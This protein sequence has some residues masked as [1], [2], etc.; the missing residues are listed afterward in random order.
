M[1]PIEDGVVT[2]P[3][4]P[5]DKNISS[6]ALRLSSI[7][8][9]APK[10]SRGLSIDLSAAPTNL[11]RW[12]HGIALTAAT[13]RANPIANAGPTITPSRAPNHR[14]TSCTLRQ[15]NKRLLLLA[16]RIQVSYV[17]LQPIALIA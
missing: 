6:K 1:A 9:G 5:I 12:R 13:P 11:T 2:T 14:L 16:L 4:L 7:R 8:Y 15:A 17:P 10:P 3:F